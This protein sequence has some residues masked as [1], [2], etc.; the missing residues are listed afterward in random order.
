MSDMLRTA[1]GRVRCIERRKDGT[2]VGDLVRWKLANGS[3]AKVYLPRTSSEGQ[4]VLDIAS[5]TAETTLELELSRLTQQTRENISSAMT[6]LL[7]ARATASE[8]SDGFVPLWRK[9]ATFFRPLLINP[10]G[11]DVVPTLS[12]RTEESET[13][14]RT[15]L[16][17]RCLV[18]LLGMPFERL[19]AMAKRRTSGVVLSE[20]DA[21]LS[22]EI[23]KIHCIRFVLPWFAMTCSKRPETSNRKDAA[24]TSLSKVSRKVDKTRT[25]NKAVGGYGKSAGVYGRMKDGEEKAPSAAAHTYS[26]YKKWEK[27]VASM[28]DDDDDETVPEEGTPTRPDSKSPSATRLRRRVSETAS[29]IDENEEEDVLEERRLDTELAR[30]L[31]QASP[32]VREKL[33]ELGGVF[34]NLTK[35]DNAST[36]R[37]W[38]GKDLDALIDRSTGLDE[39]VAPAGKPTQE[40][41]KFEA[42]SASDRKR[43]KR[44]RES[45]VRAWS[46]H[47]DASGVKL[48]QQHPTRES[49]DAWMERQCQKALRSKY[50]ATSAPLLSSKDPDVAASEREME[51]ID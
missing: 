17:W 46:R 32:Q 11:D 29:K 22:E 10:P 40:G 2:I 7:M 24:K 36:A 43:L 20:T 37:E 45:K 48:R 4:K 28:D 35:D 39:V 23:R 26:H 38:S 47:S 9:L 34:G 6:T 50:K 41:K 16:Y 8:I 25:A 13:R 18:A 14:T 27:F 1:Y 5:S 21:E 51:D 12:D 3:K 31:R 49:L 33:K 19:H 44:W 42:K 30:K 15:Q